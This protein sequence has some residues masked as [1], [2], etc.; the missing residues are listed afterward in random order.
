MEIAFIMKTLA[1][2]ASKIKSIKVD[3]N[4]AQIKLKGNGMCLITQY[5]LNYISPESKQKYFESQ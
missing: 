1:L 2:K 4:K 3:G 5:R